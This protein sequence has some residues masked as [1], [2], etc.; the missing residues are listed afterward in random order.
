MRVFV[1]VLAER[2]NQ[3]T[4]WGG[5][6][7]DDTQ[8]PIHFAGYVGRQISKAIAYRETNDAV[9]MRARFVKIAA[10]A[11]AATES[12]DR[13]AESGRGE[14]PVEYCYSTDGETYHGNHATI[15]E[16]LR[17]GIEERYYVSGSDAPSEIGSVWVGQV[18]SPRHVFD[19]QGDN[20]IDQIE[21]ELYD[22][23]GEHADS[24]NPSKEERA[25]LDALISA[26]CDA[27]L[28]LT[29][30]SVEKA[31]EYSAGNPLYD[32]A[33]ADVIAEDKRKAPEA[34]A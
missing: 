23:V 21:C 26:W 18:E 14:V 11:F 6:T 10:L 1:D 9:A 16:A 30:F 4:Q 3:D 8:Y 20:V 28:E 15:D 25:G 19:S 34:A 32:A 22:V 24:F 33:L 13:K 17:D 27:H 2:K 7:H 5:P 29:C 12:I 31:V